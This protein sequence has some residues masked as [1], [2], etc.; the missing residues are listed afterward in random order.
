MTADR[1]SDAPVKIRRALL[2]VSDKAGLVELGQ[3]LLRGDRS[4]YLLIREVHEP[5]APTAPRPLA[6]ATSAPARLPARLD[7]RT[8]A[9]Q[10][11]PPARQ[12]SR[13]THRPTR[14]TTRP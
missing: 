2:S 4:R 1:P 8:V 7:A 6:P 10:L 11:G 5:V 3:A 13:A 9:G 12:P 14:R